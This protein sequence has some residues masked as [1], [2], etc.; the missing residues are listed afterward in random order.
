MLNCRLLSLSCVTSVPLD[1]K[2]NTLHYFWRMGSKHFCLTVRLITSFSSGKMFG[3][4][5]ILVH[6]LVRVGSF[7]SSVFTIFFPQNF[8]FSLSF[9]HT[10]LDCWLCCW[11]FQDDISWFHFLCFDSRWCLKRVK[12]QIRGDAIT[13]TVW[14][15]TRTG[16]RGAVM[17]FYGINFLFPSVE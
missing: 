14:R 5:P 4:S 13:D 1:N 9:F 3:A 6:L 2:D 8:I 15:R 16:G 12:F 17:I 11:V 7:Q 10:V